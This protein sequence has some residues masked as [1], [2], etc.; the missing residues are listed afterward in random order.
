MLVPFRG[1]CKQ[2]A[3]TELK[4]DSLSQSMFAEGSESLL[5][6]LYDDLSNASKWLSVARM[7]SS[8]QTQIKILS[9]AVATVPSSLSLWQELISLKINNQDLKNLPAVLRDALGL[10]PNNSDL[11][12]LMFN[13]Q[14]SMETFTTALRNID[15]ALVWPQF[16]KFLMNSN[17]TERE[18]MTYCQN[19][20]VQYPQQYQELIRSSLEAKRP[21]TAAKLLLE[22]ENCSSEIWMVVIQYQKNNHK[23]IERALKLFPKHDEDLVPLIAQIKLET[24]GFN[25]FRS[26]V[27]HRLENASS[28]GSFCKIFAF[29]TKLYEL[30]ID[31]SMR[32][33]GQGGWKTA[34][35]LTE[36][37]NII[38]KRTSSLSKIAL[39][40]SPDNVGLWLDRAKIWESRPHMAADVIEKSLNAVNAY[41][42]YNGDVTDLQI[43]YAQLKIKNGNN[44]ADACKTLE[45]TLTQKSLRPETEIKL[46]IALA[47]IYQGPANKAQKALEIIK[48]TLNRMPENKM[49][50]THY[51]SVLAETGSPNLMNAFSSC[52]AKRAVTMRMVLMTARAFPDGSFDQIAVFE[53]GLSMFPPQLSFLLWRHYLFTVSKS[54]SIYQ[55]RE[56]FSQAFKALFSINK[57]REEL[58]LLYVMA[59]R[60][61]SEGSLI[62]ARSALKKVMPQSKNFELWLAYIGL[63]EEDPTAKRQAF[64][65]AINCLDDHDAH[66]MTL[67]MAEFEESLG[68]IQRSNMLL[69]YAS[70]LKDT[71]Q[72]QPAWKS[73]EER[74]KNVNSGLNAIDFVP[75][76]EIES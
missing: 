42:A 46:C 27:L 5:R 32:T 53:K 74:H 58:A 63:N 51:L 70:N 40:E 15:N 7:Q 31:K 44:I 65:S 72:S 48:A 24:A 29:I 34:Q 11:W 6:S 9:R 12:L 35:R 76:M 41:K 33:E 2:K 16:I 20:L 22:N 64:E 17:V 13:I 57:S 39:S 56:S 59:E 60:A 37:G 47:D 30:E 1:G 55:M 54:L 3:V 19:Y 66:L 61:H 8:P 73:I 18:R 25:D 69:Q 21:E 26:F 62:M 10:F 45:D 28:A 71:T 50:W 75:S 52:C 68:E 67:K 14:P 49:L 23:L 43:R 4:F 38:K 36:L